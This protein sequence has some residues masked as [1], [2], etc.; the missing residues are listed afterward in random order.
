MKI[1]HFQVTGRRR[2]ILGRAC[3]CL[4]VAVAAVAILMLLPGL[5]VAGPLED[6]DAAYKRGDFAEAL[7]LLRPLAEQGV[8][9]AQDNLGLLYAQGKGVPQDYSEAAKWFRLAA[10]QGNAQAQFNLGLKYDNGQGVPQDYAEAAKWFRL[11]AEQGLAEAQFNLG[12]RYSKGQGVPQDYAAAVKWYRLAAEQGDANAQHNLGAMYSHGQGV[13]QDYVQA[14]MWLNLAASRY[15]PSERRDNAVASRAW[16]ARHMTPNQVAEAQRLA[17]EWR[18]GEQKAAVLSPAPP[19]EP[20]AASAGTGFF[21]TQEGHV[22]TCAHVV[23]GCQQ[24]RARLADGGTLSAVVLATNDQDDLALLKT[25]AKP[26]YAAIFRSGSS[27]R[28]GEAIVL[29]GFPLTGLLATSGNATSGNVTALAG[30]GDEARLMQISAP[31][32]PGNSG[33]PILDQSGQVV[34][35]VLS[36]LNVF[37]VGRVIQDIPQNVNFALKSSVAM[38]FLER[39]GVSFSTAAKGSNLD[40]ADLAARAR[41]ITVL[42]ECIKMP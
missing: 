37:K 36:K 40:P 41:A 19:K 23:S 17:R 24:V 28:Q 25:D 35:L 11:A 7:R 13:P 5:A 16:L 15:P 18:P 39:R 14:Y 42:V 8:A 34:G 33:G 26:R 1:P 6:A 12:V 9:T 27:L 22:L 21:V 32:Q 30:P 29:Y 20:R 38:N 10:E 3:S 4:T 2:K 31:V